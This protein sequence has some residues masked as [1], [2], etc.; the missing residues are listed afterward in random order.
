MKK[1]QKAKRTTT[2]KITNSTISYKTCL[3]LH[4]SKNDNILGRRSTDQ[5]CKIFFHFIKRKDILNFKQP[6]ASLIPTKNYLYP[7]AWP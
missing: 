7:L 4:L 1:G 3:F 6:N 2:F 5:N